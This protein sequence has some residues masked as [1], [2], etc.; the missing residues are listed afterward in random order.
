VSC[1]EC[2]KSDEIHW[3]FDNTARDGTG[4]LRDGQGTPCEDDAPTAEPV[5][6]QCRFCFYWER[7]VQQPKD[8]GIERGQCRIRSPQLYHLDIGVYGNGWPVTQE[9]DWCG[10]FTED[11]PR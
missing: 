2:G 6:W 1:P 7:M 9:D 10:E 3:C 8:D 5:V 11:A 4:V